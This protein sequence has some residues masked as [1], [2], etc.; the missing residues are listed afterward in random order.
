MTSAASAAPFPARTQHHKLLRLALNLPA[1]STAAADPIFA[2]GGPS[3]GKLSTV[4]GAIPPA[5]ETRVVDCVRA[6]GDAA[7]FRA[8]GGRGAPPAAGRG[9]DAAGAL[10][11][12]LD[13][14]A[15]RP[16]VLVLVRAERL[17][18]A[19]FRPDAL[20]TLLSLGR[21]VARPGLL[22]VVFVSRV[23]WAALRDTFDLNVVEPRCV[24]FPA[25][26]EEELVPAVLAMT[27]GNGGGF[28]PLPGDV[29]AAAT[30]AALDEG[31]KVRGMYPGFVKATVQVLSTTSKDL[32]E[33]ARAC[34]ALYPVYLRPLV[35]EDAEMQT[36][37]L[38][39]RFDSHL[40]EAGRMLYQRELK[41][42]GNG[43]HGEG[44]R[45]G[46]QDDLVP[47]G[48]IAKTERAALSADEAVAAMDLSIV[49]KKLLLAAFLGARNPPGK[50]LHYFSLQVDRQRRKTRRS[51]GVKKARGGAM[52]SV[53]LPL[54][55]IISIFDAIQDVGNDVNMSE[56]DKN[57]KPSAISCN[58][59]TNISTLVSLSLLSRDAG[60]AVSEPKFRCSL[61]LETA[62]A[63][64]RNVNI[65]LH[66]YMHTEM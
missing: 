6:H 26:S 18:E 52:S 2:W 64:A 14:R 19:Q 60:D 25:Y 3:T 55:R 54:N 29:E 50:D 28:I 59:F 32:K 10:V 48:N 56:D 51:N 57:A 22:R 16:L 36:A 12:A 33:L 53:V 42:A 45:V 66:E 43:G 4:L 58:A 23:P 62:E 30:V 11:E 20:Q 21:L 34:T 49:N 61:S 15:G 31:D 7:L 24:W 37:A 44:G 9:A 65:E 39:P 35:D 27:G 17:R 41:I 63:L 47:E 8:V 40:A 46:A 5:A 1:P 38:W 13:R